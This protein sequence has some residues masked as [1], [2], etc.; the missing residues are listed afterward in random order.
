MTDVLLAAEGYL[1][2]AFQRYMVIQTITS[3]ST[4]RAAVAV[5]GNAGA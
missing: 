1:D 4:R 3:L 5:M 2:D